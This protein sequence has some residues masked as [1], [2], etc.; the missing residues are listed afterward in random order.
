MAKIV[1]ARHQLERVVPRE[2]FLERNRQFLARE[3]VSHAHVD[4]APEGEVAARVLARHIKT[5]RLGKNIG[6]AVRRSEAQHDH[7]ALSDLPIAK[8]GI[9]GRDA[10]K[11]GCRRKQPQHFFNHVQDQRSVRANLGF[12]IR[13]LDEQQQAAGDRRGGGFVAR[14]HQLLHDR[15][16]FRVVERTLAL[17]RR[18]DDGVQ[19]VVRPLSGAANVDEFLHALLEFDDQMRAF[20][21]A[22]A[23]CHPA[24]PVG[25]GIGPALH[26]ANVTI[27]QADLPGDHRDGQRNGE[28]MH[29]LD[30]LTSFQTVKKV[31]NDA[32]DLIFHRVHSRHRESEI[33]EL[34]E[35]RV[36]RR[37]CGQHRIDLRPPLCLDRGDFGIVATRPAH[38]GA[39]VARKILRSTGGLRN[40]LV[41]KNEMHGAVSR[42]RERPLRQ[43]SPVPGER[44][45]YDFRIEKVRQCRSGFGHLASLPEEL[46]AFFATRC[47]IEQAR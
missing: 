18:V 5:V 27:L 32:A 40:E 21:F 11:S 33:H 31:A 3:H 35:A 29:Q 19:K 34:A 16:N 9:P 13:I 46:E 44:V 20:D 23:R 30:R 41:R 7:F 26:I 1:L 15:Q 25:K 10:P 8:H 2:Q 28:V 22:F 42:A 14:N 4:A 45:F 6:I 36:D 39:K 43:C 38:H 24:Q 37:V 12:L 47:N 17:D